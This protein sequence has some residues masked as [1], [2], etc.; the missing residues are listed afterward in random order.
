MKSRSWNIV[1]RDKAYEIAKQLEHEK[2]GRDI[3]V[4]ADSYEEYFRQKRDKAKSQID[5]RTKSNI[6]QI[7]KF[8]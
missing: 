5:E 6:Y 1:G 8:S 2:R 4:F 3:F 7:R